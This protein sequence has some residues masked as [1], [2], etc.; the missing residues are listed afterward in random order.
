M[1]ITKTDVRLG[2]LLFLGREPESSSAVQ[3]K[4]DSISSIEALRDDFL[5][6]VEF[7]SKHPSISDVAV[8]H[9]VAP[10]RRIDADVSD[11]QMKKLLDRVRTQ[12]E[13]LGKDDPYWS[14][15]THD[16][17]RTANLK[18]AS[19]DSFYSSG[20]ANADLVDIFSA[21]S[22]VSVRRDVCLELGCGVGRITRFLAEKFE[23]VIAV[24]ISPGNLKI[25]ADYMNDHGVR[26]VDT[27]LITNPDQLG[28]VEDIGFFYSMIVLQH[29]A[30]PVQKLL[31]KAILP[32]ILP[33]GGCLFQTPDSFQDYEFDAEAFLQSGDAELDTHC[34]PRSVVLDLIQRYGLWVRDVV[35]DPWLGATLGSYTYFATAPSKVLPAPGRG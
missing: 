15:L 5:N 26:N 20:K 1:A 24:D 13:R 3:A 18:H 6:S 23:R 17:Y 31:L 4:V 32:K 35:P 22:N 9:Y 14:V 10:P 29:N 7:R 30:P 21:R 33:G 8:P 16:E 28:A 34:L 11:E 19:L 12:W 27:H 25:C 2:Y